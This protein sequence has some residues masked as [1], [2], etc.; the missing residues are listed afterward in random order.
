MASDRI[1]GLFAILGALAYIAG[2]SQTQTSFMSDPMGPKAFPYLIGG[3]AVLSGLV[4]VI[5]PNE[6][7]DWPSLKTFGSLLIAVAVMVIYAK[8]LKPLGFL[9]PT[10]VTAAILSYQISPRP[11]PALLVGVGLSAGLYALFKFV[12]GL[13]LVALPKG[14]F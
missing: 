3:A 1:F 13:S 14:L 5:R 11:V 10:A 8:T 6:E 12:L 4:M 7:P 2:A 9:I